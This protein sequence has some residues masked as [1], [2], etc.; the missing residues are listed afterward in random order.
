MVFSRLKSWD[1]ASTRTWNPMHVNWPL[2]HAHTR[3]SHSSL[4]IEGSLLIGKIHL[5]PKFN[6]TSKEFSSSSTLMKMETLPIFG[7][8]VDPSVGRI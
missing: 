2:Y 7:I 4:I 6:A 1:V 3:A 5:F 8:V